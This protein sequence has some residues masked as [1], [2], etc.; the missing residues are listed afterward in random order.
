MINSKSAFFKA[1]VAVFAS[2]IIFVAVGFIAAAEPED[3]LPESIASEQE[4]STLSQTTESLT[5]S[6]ISLVESSQIESSV[7]S[8]EESSVVSSEETSA[9]SS[10]VSE[11]YYQ[12]DTEDDTSSKIKKKK[13]TTAQSQVE[14]DEPREKKVSFFKK[15]EMPLIIIVLLGIAAVCVY[16]LIR[17]NRK[18]SG[19]LTKKEQELL[20]NPPLTSFS[21]K[22]QKNNRNLFDEFDNP[23]DE[24]Q[25]DDR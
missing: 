16:S 11:Y 23:D 5:E 6:E 15:I 21:T 24:N 4:H 1:F 8:I 2:L 25:S 17:Y 3:S 10:E 14:E 7:E 12:E 19:K 9:E 22:G 13:E 20:D 18:M